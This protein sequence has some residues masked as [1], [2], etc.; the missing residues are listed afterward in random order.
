MNVAHST[1]AI[2]DG[3][4]FRSRLQSCVGVKQKR[5]AVARGKTIL[6]AC[7]V[8]TALYL[9][10]RGKMRDSA[11]Q[12]FTSHPMVESTHSVASCPPRRCAPRSSRREGRSKTMTT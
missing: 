3:A 8:S 2:E 11:V 9:K 6:V 4:T 10:A 12:R 5:E 1:H 7:A